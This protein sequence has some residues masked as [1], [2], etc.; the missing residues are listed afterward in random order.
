MT[1]TVEPPLTLWRLLNEAMEQAL[2]FMSPGM[3]PS[4]TGLHDR[5]LARILATHRPKPAR[6]EWDAEVGDWLA[7]WEKV[8]A[9]PASENVLYDGRFRRVDRYFRA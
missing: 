8:H 5:Y 7:P 2:R 3:A 4:P 9:A 1:K 6:L